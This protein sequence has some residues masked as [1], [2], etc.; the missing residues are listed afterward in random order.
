MFVVKKGSMEN[1]LSALTR[2]LKE[3]SGYELVGEESH[4]V[5]KPFVLLVFGRTMN[6]GPFSRKGS[7]SASGE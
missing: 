2:R 7:E 4:E 1:E 3:S 5:P 6:P